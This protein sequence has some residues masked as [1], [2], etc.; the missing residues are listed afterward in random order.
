MMS[1]GKINGRLQLHFRCYSR[2]DPPP[3]RVKPIPIQVLCRLACVAAASRDPELQAVKDMIR[4]AFFFL[5]R[6]GEYTG[7]KSGSSPF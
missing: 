2:K 5:L 1:T 6:P 7:M 3:S 4:I